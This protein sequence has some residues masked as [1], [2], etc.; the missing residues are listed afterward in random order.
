L[1]PDLPQKRPLEKLVECID[2]QNTF[3]KW[4]KRNKHSAKSMVGIFYC[5]QQIVEFIIIS[6]VQNNLNSPVII[7]VSKVN[8]MW[9]SITV[10]NKLT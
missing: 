4:Q 7:I 10:I 8:R 1:R 9:F 6:R 2:L 5:I 3:A